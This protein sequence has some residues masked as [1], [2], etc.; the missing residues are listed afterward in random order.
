[1][2]RPPRGNRWGKAPGQDLVVPVTCQTPAGRGAVPDLRRYAE[3]AGVRAWFAEH[4]ERQL[5]ALDEYLAADPAARK[6]LP[7]LPAVTVV[8]AR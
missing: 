1:M 5:P 3:D 6:P 8:N 7:E 4:R 2:H